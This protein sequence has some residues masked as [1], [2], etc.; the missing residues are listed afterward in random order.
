MG[1][2]L[3]T[4][5]HCGTELVATRTKEIGGSWQGLK[6]TRPDKDSVVCPNEDCVG[7]ES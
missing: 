7:D 3:G 4:C 5:P 1:F 6:I 2:D